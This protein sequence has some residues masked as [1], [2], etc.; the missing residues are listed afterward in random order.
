M[1]H[2]HDPPD[3]AG[4]AG[5][6]RRRVVAAT[7]VGAGLH[8]GGSRAT[9]PRVL[10]CYPTGPIYDYRWQLLRE[11]L[12]RGGPLAASHRMEPYPEEVTQNR[13]IA[14]LEAG[15]ID[16]IALGTN[17]ERE[18]RLLP[19]R[20]DILRGMVGLRVFI[21]RKVD[22]ARFAALTEAALRR[23]VTFGLNSQWADV[24]VL[25]ENG[26][27]VVTSLGYENLFE[28][29]AAG[30][31]DA[32]PRGLNE[33]R[34]ELAERTAGGGLVVERTLALY[35]PFP[36]YFWVRK[37]DDT[38]AGDITRGLAASLRDGAFRR[39]FEAHHAEDIAEMKATRRRVIRLRSPI[40][41][42]GSPAVDTG[43]WWPASRRGS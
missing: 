39:L 41:P 40:L 5:L 20:E 28:M 4:D 43:W 3:P 2:T 13:G 25:R 7:A 22:E 26:F 19:I 36:I 29:L 1:T 15:A 24:P 37:G 23:D 38:L 27:R 18:A 30:R 32:F 8:A 16:V 42:P 21:I 31:F 9:G 14:L 10:R 12:A 35:F 11:V 34:R 6:T 33:A 17:A